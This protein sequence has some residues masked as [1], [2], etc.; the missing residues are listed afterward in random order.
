MTQFTEVKAGN[1]KKMP[2]KMVIY[3]EP[4]TG[5]TT[6]ASQADDVFFINVEGGLDYLQKEV[7]STPHLSTAEE[8]KGWLSHIYKDETF[9]AG[10]IVIDSIDWVERIVQ[11]EL[12]K[13]EGAQGITDARVFPYYRGVQEAAEKTMEI[14]KWL[15]AIYKK[16]GIPSLLIAHS[17]VKSIDLPHQDAFSR[18]EMKLSK[19]LGAKVNEWADLILMAGYSFHIDK[20]GKAATEPKRVLYG[21]GS[22][23]WVGGGRMTLKRELPLDYNALKKEITGGN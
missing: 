21:G 19:M 6:F 5:K 20:D 9:T 7:R 3:G 10:L 14:L 8:I 1:S 17:Q 13:R 15:D 11:E 23:A 12:V 2:P 16:K 4:K 18:H 22:A